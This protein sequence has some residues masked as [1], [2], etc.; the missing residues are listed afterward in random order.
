MGLDEPPIAHVERLL[1]PSQP[2]FDALVR[3]YADALPPCECKSVDALREMIA[4]PEYSFLAAKDEDAVVGFSI[5]I[6]LLDSDAALLEYMAVDR[7][8][9]GAGVGQQL[10]HATASQPQFRGRL[11]LIELDAEATHGTDQ[12][13][14]ARRKAF[15]RRLGCRRIEGLTYLMPQVSS[16]RPPLMDM[17]VHGDNLPDSIEKPRMRTWLTAC[18]RQVYDVGGEDTRIGEMLR[19]LPESISLI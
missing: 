11:L 13:I 16:A 8:R 15:Y 7:E 12:G 1:S 18:Y 19:G 6:A 4:R 3:I 5:A 2:E 10:F 17:L 9:R 14:L